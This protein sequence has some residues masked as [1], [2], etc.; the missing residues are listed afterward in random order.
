MP[1]FFGVSTGAGAACAG[2]A[3]AG[4]ARAR[5]LILDKDLFIS[6]RL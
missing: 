4:A 2:A 1:L 5:D 3:C 6:S